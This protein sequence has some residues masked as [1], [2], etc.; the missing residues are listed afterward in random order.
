MES[1][2]EMNFNE[3]INFFVVYYAYEMFTDSRET[4][5]LTLRVES[6]LRVLKNRILKRKFSFKKDDK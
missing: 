6:K 4:G 1:L 3:N 5:V 2:R